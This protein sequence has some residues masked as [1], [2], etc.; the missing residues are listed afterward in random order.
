[1]RDLPRVWPWCVPRV[2]HVLECSEPGFLSLTTVDT[3]PSTPH[4]LAY[5]AASVRIST[6]AKLT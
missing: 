3:S 2:H 5:S 1:M 6:S 4:S